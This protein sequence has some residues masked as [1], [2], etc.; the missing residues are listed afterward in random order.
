MPPSKQVLS[1]GRLSGGPKLIVDVID[2]GQGNAILVSYPNG[3]YMLVDCGSLATSTSGATFKHAQ[4]YITSVT[5]GSP[6]TTVVITHGDTDHTAFI[7]YIKEAQKPSYVFYGGKEAWLDD[8]VLAWVKKQQARAGCKVFCFP[9]KGYTST[10]PDADFGGADDENETDVYVLG[11]NYGTTPNDKSVVLMLCYETQ[12]VVLTGDAEWNAE[13]EILTK[14]P[15]KL[16]KRCTV[17]MPAHHGS[18]YSTTQNWLNALSPLIAPVSAS[19]TNMSYAHPDC[20]TLEMVEA[21]VLNSADKHRGVCSDGRG[22]AYKS[23]DTTRAI[24]VTA[25]NGDIRY[26]TDG[27]NYNVKIS[28]LGGALMSAVHREA[29]IA[30]E[31]RQQKEAGDER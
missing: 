31:M 18:Y 25:T 13:T 17:F 23:V 9:S 20:M 28:S 11:A 29:I 5:G 15:K 12:A 3:N 24:F 30:E 6:I 10:S 19:G 21:K 7:P 8:D 27:T 22:K 16:L 2:V 14:V 4:A 1:S 26:T